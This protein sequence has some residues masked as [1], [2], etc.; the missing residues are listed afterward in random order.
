MVFDAEVDD[1]VGQLRVAAVALDDE[2][3]RGLLAALVAACGLCGREAI[4]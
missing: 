2:Q 1:D 4:E 3:R